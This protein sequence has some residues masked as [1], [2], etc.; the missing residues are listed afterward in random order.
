MPARYK[1]LALMFALTMVTYLDRVCIAA[2]APAMSAELGLSKGQM[3]EVFSIF[4]LG[5]VLFEIPG[6]WLA[7]RFGARSLLTRI[8]VCWSVFTAATG[9][10]GSF[11]SL[12]V[13][14]FLFGCGEAGAF[15]GCASA[16]SRWFPFSERG[17]AQAVIMVGS[18]LGG[19]F[20]PALVIALMSAIGWRA[21]FWVFA[22]LGIVWAVAW[23][24]W[25]RNSPEQHGAVSAGE[26]ALIQSGRT[27]RI[28]AHNGAHAVPWARLLR[29][30]NI[31][32]LCGMYSGYAFGLYFYLSWL[33]TYL[34]EERGIAF[35]QIGFFAALPLLVGAVCNF[36]GG[37]LTD[38][39]SRRMS[40]RWA[41]RLPAMGGLFTAAGL[42]AVAALAEGKVVGITALALSFGAADLILAVCWAT[43]LDIGRDHAGTVSGAMN[44][45]GQIG[46]VI[47]PTAIGWMV[48]TWGS[49]QLPLLIA[50][51]YY[52]L[53]GLLWLLI[54]P[55]QPL[56][57]AGPSSVPQARP[58]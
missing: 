14:R 25:F 18:R 48:E 28:G 44:S 47:A 43:C 15:P 51:G 4:V 11:A 45:L 26:L 7:D 42:L 32:A 38:F 46:G 58:W 13:I 10:A 23:S 17:R 5:Y 2:T 41:R 34:Q 57:L 52:V 12:L 3:G 54:D 29:S 39:L 50:A 24:S 37:W 35:E 33:P 9:M 6:G 55:E 40:L 27:T 53:A 56:D 36:L 22:L 16:I 20:A 8:V 49:W 21:V 31:W 19:A 1:A 30:R